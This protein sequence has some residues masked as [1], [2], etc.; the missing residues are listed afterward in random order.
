M[1]VTYYVCGKV[2]LGVVSLCGGSCPDRGYSRLGHSLDYLGGSGFVNLL[3]YLLIGVVFIELLPYILRRDIQRFGKG[4]D[5]I[6]LAVDFV[7]LGVSA[8]NLAVHGGFL[9]HIPFGKGSGVHKNGVDGYALCQN[10]SVLV[11]YS[12]AVCLDGCCAELLAVCK[13][14]ILFAFLYGDLIHAERHKHH[15]GNHYGEY[16]K[17]KSSAH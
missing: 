11:V 8:H 4:G 2:V 16:Y 1:Q 9:A 17:V 12:A 13:L 5:N 7:L 6:F 15:A 10:L 14:L 3:G